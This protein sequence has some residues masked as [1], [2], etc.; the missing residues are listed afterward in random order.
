MTVYD[1]LC[2]NKK[3]LTSVL[4]ILHMNFRFVSPCCF[5]S[6]YKHC[7]KV[8]FFIDCGSKKSRYLGFGGAA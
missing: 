3:I 4:D 1:K 5:F 8:M 6:I 7:P 2:Q